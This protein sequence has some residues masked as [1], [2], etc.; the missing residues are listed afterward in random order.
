[1]VKMYLKAESSSTDVVL[2]DYDFSYPDSEEYHSVSEWSQDKF[3]E[4][5]YDKSKDS[6]VEYACQTGYI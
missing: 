1:M 6:V 2:C 5:L 3:I 4:K